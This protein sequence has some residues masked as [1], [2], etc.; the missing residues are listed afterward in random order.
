MSPEYLTPVAPVP[1]IKP[2]LCADQYAGM[3]LFLLQVVARLT[4]LVG[5]IVAEKHTRST[6]TRG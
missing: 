5:I 3:G 2:S 4:A 6:K 1:A